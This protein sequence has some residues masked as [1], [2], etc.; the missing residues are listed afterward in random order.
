M[1]ATMYCSRVPKRILSGQFSSARARSRN[2]SSLKKEM[3][4]QTTV[5][6]YELAEQLGKLPGYALVGTR[7]IAAMTGFAV[8]S[9]RQRKVAL[10]PAVYRSRRKLL[11]RIEDVRSWLKK[12]DGTR[13]AE[14]SRRQVRHS[15]G[16]LGLGTE[17]FERDSQ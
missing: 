1:V 5:R 9:I 14:R 17:I 2:E 7:E 11:W 6:D 4:R 13:R 16:P 12:L 15:D 10:P 8:T 3:A